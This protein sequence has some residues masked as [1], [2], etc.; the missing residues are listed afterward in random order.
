MKKMEIDRVKP[1]PL[2]FEGVDKITDTAGFEPLD[3]KIKRFMLSGEVNKLNQSLFDSYDYREMM[4]VV[5]DIV[6]DEYDE[7]EE[8]ID[9]INALNKKRAEILA[10]KTDQKK[11]A[12]PVGPEK[13]EGKT[14][15]SVPSETK[16]EELEAD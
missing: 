4:S 10:R 1:V 5:P 16:R 8:T 13:G 2:S 7:F 12:T 11:P 6:V 14:G 15:E 9:V 3:C